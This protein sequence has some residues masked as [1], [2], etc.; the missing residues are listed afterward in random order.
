ME[1]ATLPYRACVGIMLINHDGRVFCGERRDTPGAWQMPQGGIQKGEEPHVAALREL[2]EEIGV[3]KAEIIGQTA[4]TYTYDFP[5]FL[6]HRSVY[7]GKYRGQE[8]H[9]FALRFL[10]SD[11]DID[12]VAHNDQEGPEFTAWKWVP[13][14]DVPRLIV[15]FKRAVYEHV[16]AEFAPLIDGILKKAG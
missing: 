8:Q 9:W 14:T 2:H 5:D 3:S 12:L 6:Q 1:Y 11:A 4:K 16:T 15:P 10:G 13:H 7:K